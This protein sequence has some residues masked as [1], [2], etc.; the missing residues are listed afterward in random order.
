MKRNVQMKHIGAVRKQK[1][2]ISWVCVCSLSYPASNV[3]ASVVF[4]AVHYFPTLSQ[5]GKIFEEKKLFERTTF[6]LATNQRVVAIVSEDSRHPISPI[7]KGEKSFFKGQEPF[8]DSCPLKMAP[9]GCPE[10]SARNNQYSLR[11]NQEECNSHLLR[12]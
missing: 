4:A 3:H 2:Y 10:T 8:L 9:I 7:S 12:G 5:K 6:F 1:Y 11:S